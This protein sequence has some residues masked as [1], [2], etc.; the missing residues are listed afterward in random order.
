MA[1]EVPAVRRHSPRGATTSDLYAR[2]TKQMIDLLEKGTVPWRSPILGRGNGGHPKNLNSGKPYRGVNIFLLAFTAYAQ[3]YESR[4]WLTYQQALGRGG[5]VKKGEHGTPV[6]F[7][8][9]LEKVEPKTGVKKTAFVLRSYVVFNADQCEGIE[10]PDGVAFTPLPFTP[11]EAAEQVAKGYLDG[12][13]I[14]H[15]GGMAY[16]R[17]VEDKVRLPETQRFASSEEYY[18][19]LFHE[20][21][22]STG[23]SKRLDRKLDSQLQPFGSPDY[24]KEELVAEMSAAFLCA[25]TGIAPAVIDNQAAYLFGWLGRLKQDS[26]LIVHAAGAAQRSADWI[27]GIRGDRSEAVDQ[28][29]P[30]GEE[31][32]DLGPP[33]GDEPAT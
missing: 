23:H 2:V 8:K 20:L 26:K 28:T 12:P 7:W 3:G 16:Y 25:E 14:D 11:V 6:I 1:E 5:H 18:S 33:G 19:T 32:T 27:R 31:A 24:S 15:G 9:P 30:V 17:P 10:K 13:V 22:H 21:S 4:Y 29:L